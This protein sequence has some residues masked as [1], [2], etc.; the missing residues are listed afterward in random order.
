MNAMQK[1]VEHLE[2]HNRALK[3]KVA[4][5]N[6]SQPSAAVL[7]EAIATAVTVEMAKVHKDAATFQAD[8]TSN[9]QLALKKFEGLILAE[10][11]K[12]MPTPTP[13]TVQ[14]PVTTQEVLATPTPATSAPNIIDLVIT[15]PEDDNTPTTSKLRPASTIQPPQA[16]LKGKERASPLAYLE[17]VSTSSAAASEVSDDDADVHVEVATGVESADSVLERQLALYS[18]AVKLKKKPLASSPRNPIATAKISAQ[19]PL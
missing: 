7:A 18:A 4:A 3:L 15:I 2:A 17:T 14:P 8:V 9:F 1:R 10:T 6:E 19:P 11:A 12:R 13:H 5:R 16:S